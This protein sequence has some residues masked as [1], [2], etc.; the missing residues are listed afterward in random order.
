MA[1]KI[2]LFIETYKISE[3]SFFF[4]F[5][6]VQDTTLCAS[7]ISNET[8]ASISPPEKIKKEAKSY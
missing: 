6:S 5:K 8:P 3:K 7:N 1:F 4:F 2:D